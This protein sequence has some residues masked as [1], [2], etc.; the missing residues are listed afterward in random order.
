MKS[1]PP[2]QEPGKLADAVIRHIDA[3]FL[4]D[5][6][7][8]YPPRQSFRP[9]SPYPAEPLIESALTQQPQGF[10]LYLH[11]PFCRQICGFCNL[12]ALG[13]TDRD[14]IDLYIE[15]LLAEMSYY[16]THL[17]K[18][19]SPKTIYFGGGTPS[20]LSLEQL[21]RVLRAVDH[22]FPGS[23][24]HAEEV[25]M[26]VAPDSLSLD[27][28]RGF[29]ELG[30]SR[31]SLGAQTLNEIELR[32]IGRNHGV[33]TI[34]KAIDNALSAGIG[35]VCVDLI[36]GLPS[37][38]WS[39]WTNSV[40]DLIRIGPPTICTYN[41]T[42]RPSTGFARKERQVATDAERYQRY[43]AAQTLLLEAG[44]T[45]ET[46]VRYI[47]P[48]KGGYKQKVYHWKG[49][50]ILGLGAGARTYTPAIH[51][52]NG[53]SATK[54]QL[55]LKNYFSNISV[56][57]HS[58][59]EGIVLSEKERK[60]QALVLNTHSLT[61]D[62]L[63]IADELGLT[64]HLVELYSLLEEKRLAQIKDHELS[65]TRSGIM[66]RDIISHALFSEEVRNLSTT[67]NYAA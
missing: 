64:H 19:P 36:N 38:T 18:L 42:S 7:Y 45:Q 51:Y 39:D 48:G 28:A 56:R 43:L 37:Q 32:V 21:E 2:I 52:N 33:S 58:L 17:A 16:A 10:H 3:S 40:R 15:S 24:D 4:P 49:E 26:E 41:L 6:V 34:F 5:Y 1:L 62:H 47:K 35:D 31:V 13:K 20:I 61:H 66:Y 44:Y 27:K 63:K 65:L 30:F 23:I 55:V 14:L 67:Y 25:C 46:H 54:R 53:Y 22:A 9:L 59:S 8:S 57:G 29:H 60:R 12:F 11:F 50:T